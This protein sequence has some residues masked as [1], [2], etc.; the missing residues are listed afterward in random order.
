MSSFWA[1]R[2]IYDNLVYTITLSTNEYKEEIVNMR[3]IYLNK[4]TGMKC[5][6]MWKQSWTQNKIRKNDEGAAADATALFQPSVK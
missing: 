6:R 2:N 3:E 4:S 1:S 5:L